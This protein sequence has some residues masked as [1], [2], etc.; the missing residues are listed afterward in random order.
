MLSTNNYSYLIKKIDEF[1]RKYYLNKVVRGILY[2]FAVFFASYTVITVAEY[3]GNFSPLIRTIL[4]YGFLLLNGF[5]LTKWIVVPLLKYYKLGKNLSHEQASEIIGQHFFHVKDKLLNTLQL[6]KLSDEIPQQ[7]SLIDASINQKISDLTPV[8]FSSAIKIK[9]NRKYLKY[10]LPPLAIILL[11]AV[12]APA[13]FSETTERLIKH[14][15]KFIKKAPF[16]FV[17]LNKNL[18]S[19]QGEDF[20][21]QIKMSG[22]EIPQDIY[23]KDG[24]NT[25]KLDKQNIIRFSYTFRNLQ[26]DKNIRLQAGEFESEPYTIEVKRKPTL[27]NFDVFLQYPAYLNKKN[28]N[29]SNSGDLTIPA[30]T[31]I[32]WKFKTDN[33]SSIQMSIAGKRFTLKPSIENEFKYSYKALQS[34]TFTAKPINSEVSA[35]EQTS[36]NIK[37][38]P[39]LS[40]AIQITERADS[41][42]NKLMYFVGQVSDDHGFSSLT[43]N[44]RVLDKGKP[45]HS[46][47]RSVAFNKNAIQSNFFH[48]WDVNKTKAAP[49]QQIEYYFEVSDND[50]VFG[51]KTT[52]SAV[53]T[54]NVPTLVEA[55][56]SIEE[57]S[58]AVQQK[59]SQAVKQAAQIER[60]AKKLTQ[61]LINTKNLSFEEKRQIE[62]LMEKQ[63]SLEKLVNE[64]KAENKQKQLNQQDLQNP[65]QEILDKQKQIEDLFNNVLDEKTKDLLKNIERLL[66]QNNKTQTQE[67]LSNMQVD[68]KTLQKELDRILELYK[69]LEFEQKL[70]STIDK[71]ITQAKKQEKLA[72]ESLQKDAD[73]KSL[74]DEQK[75][76]EK[77]FNNLKEDIQDLKE[78]NEQLEQKST[79]E[80]TDKE[81]QQIEQQQEESSKS[82]ENK[83]N[84]K[85]AESQ[86][87]AAEQMRQMAK[88]MK[89]SQEQ[90]EMESLQVN[91]Q[92]LREVLANLLT[93]SFEQEKVML[94][95]K[96][97]SP[98]DPGYVKLT[99]NQKDIKNNLK[100]VQD[101]LYSLSRQIP[102]IESVINKEIQ[103]INTNIDLALQQLA[104]RR[105]PEAGRSQQYALTSINNLALMLSKVEQQLQKAM[106]NTKG[107]S[108]GKGSP[109]LSQLAKMQEQLNKNMQAAKKQMQQ[110]GQNPGQGKTGSGKG[111][112]SE[113]MAKMAREQQLIRQ[114][115]KDINRELNKD[116][117][118]TLGNLDKLTKEMEQTETDLVNKNIQQE[119]LIRQQD[120]LTKLLDADKAERERDL[121]TQRDSKQ[122]KDQ[123][124]KNKIVLE[125][126]NKIKLRELELLKTVPPTLNSFY[127]LKVGDYFRLLNTK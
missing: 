76:L 5:I 127:K 86:Q 24:V 18:S 6:K 73:P 109:S 16:E 33:T 89:E 12:T 101:T 96:R 115:L 116:G 37:V 43:F 93:S 29:I 91:I 14:D 46:Q 8:P 112:M 54:F 75:A 113:Q 36:Y 30:G 125:E 41:V 1:I 26:N 2:L 68:N 99:Q 47:F 92:D 53:K 7:K 110:Q 78:K 87:K 66:E 65:P 80:N 88:K 42:N 120:I 90:N 50:E 61:D 104:E 57:S 45:I 35:S 32:N 118:G 121:D 11:I 71:L 40:P 77:E 51:A 49:G 48:V 59:M 70:N 114:A 67:E 22:N 60:D 98:N 19:V 122:G 95:L 25:F 56:K 34:T 97:T 27:L 124:Q 69:K 119:T 52:Q 84:K 106:Q 105:T 38:I 21:L 4:F 103:T 123:T 58:K 102:Q 108:K 39:D 79:L 62:Q 20:E 55:E 31:Q 126:F 74:K 63:R 28:E 100:M 107:S 111:Q 44:Y 94:T 72:K 85:A 117:K 3:F 17:I 83:N 10:A 81:E 15:K 13:I 82:L 23:V 64:I 9:E